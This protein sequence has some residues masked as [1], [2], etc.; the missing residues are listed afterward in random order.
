MKLQK[1]NFRRNYEHINH[2]NNWT[3]TFLEDSKILAKKIVSSDGIEQI[4]FVK[5]GITL[6]RVSKN[7]RPVS[8]TYGTKKETRGFNFG[9]H[10]ELIPVGKDVSLNTELETLDNLFSS[11]DV[12][13]AE[14]LLES[15]KSHNTIDIP[16]PLKSSSFSLSRE[17]SLEEEN[18]AFK[19]YSIFIPSNGQPE[20]IC[21]INENF[22]SVVHSASG[23]NYL[24]SYKGNETEFS[25]AEISRMRFNSGRHKTFL[26]VKRIQKSIAFVK[27][28][29]DGELS[30]E[31]AATIKNEETKIA[32]KQK[33]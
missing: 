7:G 18:G 16:E 19:S 20:T 13:V 2:L 28:I 5:P 4:I 21:T 22:V 33:Q 32:T 15:V 6:T 17:V 30:I 14:G 29:F 23:D 24:L 27:K 12:L 1:E 26:H 9:E 3:I 31:E 10:G 11:P 8:S 25:A